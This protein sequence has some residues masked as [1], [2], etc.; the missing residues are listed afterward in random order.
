[1]S[2]RARCKA[3][4][5]ASASVLRARG[6]L[7]IKTAMSPEF[8]RRTGEP[9]TVVSG[10][11]RTGEAELIAEFRERAAGALSP[12]YVGA[13]RPRVNDTSDDPG[14]SRTRFLPPAN[15]RVASSSGR[16]PAWVG[17]RRAWI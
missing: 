14:R 9:T 10:A 17:G 7:R 4:S 11:V 16:V 8:S 6:R 13:P 3:C 5:V 2:A 12:A 15:H 1:M